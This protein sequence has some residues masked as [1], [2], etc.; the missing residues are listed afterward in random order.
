MNCS[1]IVVN[2]L[3]PTLIRVRF[4]YIN[5]RLV[6]LHF[7]TH[8][9]LLNINLN[10]VLWLRERGMNYEFEKKNRKKKNV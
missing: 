4:F 8:N 3:N 2:Q 9:I 5:N 10:I 1:L 7:L 6:I